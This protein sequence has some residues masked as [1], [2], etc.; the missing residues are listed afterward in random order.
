[1]TVGTK[2][3]GL[4]TATTIIIPSKVKPICKQSTK[5]DGNNSSTAPMSL[6][7]RF[8]ILPDG[9]VLK[10]RIVALV[11]LSNMRSCNLFEATMQV[12]KKAN[13][14]IKEMTTVATVIPE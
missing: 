7:N 12:L 6:E 14:R 1:M 11:I 5:A 9:L 13:E 2:S 4:T 8:K 10:K 3:H